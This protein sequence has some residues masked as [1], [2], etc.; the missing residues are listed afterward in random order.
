[1][2]ADVWKFKPA[3]RRPGAALTWFQSWLFQ[4]AAGRFQSVK[5]PSFDE[6]I[7]NVIAV[8][9]RRSGKTVGSRAVT[10]AGGLDDGPGDVG[11]MAPTL[12]QAK[13]LLWRPLMQDLRDPAAKAF[14]EGKPNNSELTIEFK[15]GTRLYL[16]SADAYERVRGDGFKLF[17]TDETDDP[18]FTDEVFDEAVRPALSDNLGLLLQLGT[19]KGRGRLYREYR[20]GLAGDHFDPSY[21]TIQVT[22]LE[23]GIIARS[24]I[25]RARK[26]L[27]K[28]AFEQEYLATFNAPVGLVYDEWNEERHVVGAH[29]IPDHFD[30]YIAGVDWGTAARGSMLIAGIDRISLPATDDYDACELPRIWILEEHTASGVP[31]TDDGWW[32]IARDLQRQYHPTRWYCDPSGGSDEGTAARAEGYLRQLANVLSTVDNGARVVPA[33]NRV[34]P[35]ISAVQQFLHFD[36]VLGEKPRF[37]VLNTCKN[38][39]GEFGSYRWAANA[40]SEDEFEDRPVKQ[41][42]HCFVA[43]TMVMTERGSVPIETVSS[44]DR[45]LTRL[46]YRQV[47]AAGMTQESAQTFVVEMSNGASLEGT[48]NHPVWIVGHGWKRLDALRYGDILQSWR[49]F[50][51]NLRSS[52]STVLHSGATPSQSEGNCANTTAVAAGCV[53]TVPCGNSTTAL[54]RR[55]ITSITRTKT[56]STTTSP[57]SNACPLVST[58]RSTSRQKSARAVVHGSQGSGHWQPLGTEATQGARG[59][60]STAKASGSAECQPSEPA[61]SAAQSTRA[62]PCRRAASAATTASRHGDGAPGSITS[63]GHAQSAAPHTRSG[64]IAASLPVRVLAVRPSPGRTAVYDLTVEDVPEFFANGVLVHNCLDSARYLTHTHFFGKRRPGGRNDGAGW[65]GRGR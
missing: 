57:T 63:S 47:V 3:A 41:N 28:R 8:A 53:C 59:M 37:F 58:S 23:A 51:A 30:E 26:A 48:G 19:P 27:P 21:S 39:I 31:Y 40:K 9:A 18:N 44:A 16:Y 24:E 38:L 64:S 54:C 1:M 42:D 65:E 50:T 34:S 7:R 61:N 49:A 56:R 36:D 10:I 55:V 2:T 4:Q 35:G 29:Q 25:E 46:G 14:I 33:D 62:L 13:R 5:P 6:H 12:G 22:S 11:Y 20:K 52:S 15:S 17:I 43:G 32:K 45:V 60:W